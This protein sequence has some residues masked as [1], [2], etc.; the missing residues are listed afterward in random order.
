MNH[1]VA[2]TSHTQSSLGKDAWSA[3]TIE[4]AEC[5]SISLLSSDVSFLPVFSSVKRLL[6]QLPFSSSDRLRELAKTGFNRETEHRS[7]S[8][9]SEGN[10]YESSVSVFKKLTFSSCYW[11]G[12]NW[13]SPNLGLN[14]IAWSVANSKRP[15][16]PA[17]QNSNEISE[18]AAATRKQFSRISIENLSFT[19][20][21]INEFDF[22]PHGVVHKRAFLLNCDIQTDFN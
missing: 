19:R 8:I 16:K 13:K 5:N 11:R 4:L 7:A 3:I 12:L 6:P 1:S 20:S 22:N 15:E 21:Q 18:F 2:S 10:P 17:R 14:R 9:D